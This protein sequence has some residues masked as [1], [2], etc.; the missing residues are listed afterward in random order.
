[1]AA[2][3]DIGK[4]RKMQGE[5]R[6]RK[7]VENLRFVPD[8]GCL[9]SKIFSIYSL[10]TLRKSKQQGRLS[11]QNRQLHPHLASVTRRHHINLLGWQ[12][13]RQIWKLEHERVS[14]SANSVERKRYASIQDKKDAAD[15]LVHFS[16][17][18]TVLLGHHVHHLCRWTRFMVARLVVLAKT[19]W[20]RQHLTRN[21]RWREGDTLMPKMVLLYCYHAYVG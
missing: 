13:A 8:A 12:R 11:G 6:P 16:Q 3:T 14:E 7:N 17:A 10:R 2:A 9:F 21:D 5:A 4:C 19:P 18:V 20:R 1:M 15:W